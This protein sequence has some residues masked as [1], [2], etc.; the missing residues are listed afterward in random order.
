MLRTT[1]M[2]IRFERSTQCC[3]FE[4]DGKVHAFLRSQFLVSQ[5]RVEAHVG[6]DTA[7]NLTIL[8]TFEATTGIGT[9]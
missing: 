1:Q 9:T 8:C 2:K 5:E 6:R 4:S 7:I 3:R